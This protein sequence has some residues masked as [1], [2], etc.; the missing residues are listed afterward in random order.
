MTKTIPPSK[1]L[2]V[3]GEEVENRT[4]QEKGPGRGDVKLTVPDDLSTHERVGMF[5]SRLLPAIKGRD[6]A[7]AL[8]PWV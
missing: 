1:A 7:A 2:A 4:P 3:K 8:V 6:A 5:L